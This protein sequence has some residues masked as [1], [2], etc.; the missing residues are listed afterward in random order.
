MVAAGPIQPESIERAR[1]LL[2][3]VGLTQRID[4]RPPS[5][6]AASGSGRPGPGIDPLAPVAIGR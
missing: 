6:P 4:H 1:M 3:R 5:F 2:D